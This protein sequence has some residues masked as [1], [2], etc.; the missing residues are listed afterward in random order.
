M[1]VFLADTKEFV[2]QI[3]RNLCNV[4]QIKIIKI[5]ISFNVFTDCSRTTWSDSVH[6]FMAFD[7][8]RL[9]AKI[10]M[11]LIFKCFKFNFFLDQITD[12]V[13]QTK[14]VIVDFQKNM[15]LVEK[16]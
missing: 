11:I 2:R 10:S 3:G 8:C 12:L 13:Y 7:G 9:P 16:N 5:L 15:L 4:R 6:V 1:L 14:L